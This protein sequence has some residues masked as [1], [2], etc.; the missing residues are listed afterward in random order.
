M[1]AKGTFADNFTSGGNFDALGCTLMGFEFWHLITFPTLV[2]SVTLWGVGN[3]WAL[4]R[5]YLWRT[6]KIRLRPV[7]CDLPSTTTWSPSFSTILFM[8]SVPISL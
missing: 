1:V 6:I 4:V 3:R 2:D 8:S 5:P 7:I